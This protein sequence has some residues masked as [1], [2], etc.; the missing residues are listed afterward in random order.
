MIRV[1]IIED[2]TAAALN[3]RSLINELEPSAQIVTIL[4]SVADSVVWFGNEQNSA[5]VVFMDI[6]LAD[7]D[8]FNIFNH[9][10]IDVPIIFA[11]AYDQYALKAFEVN[12]IAYLLKPIKTSDL[13]RALDKFKLF[14]LAD[15]REYASRVVEA[16]KNRNQDHTFLIAIRDKL[17]PLKS[18]EI[19]FSYTF[20]ERVTITTNN[21]ST[22]PYDRSLDNMMALLPDADF[23]RANRQF[24]VSRRAVHDMSLW[25]GS[26]LCLNLVLPTPEKIIISKARVKALK[27]WIANRGK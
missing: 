2:E 19:A 9:S 13:R 15:R 18:S 21:G 4:E 6:H 14:T 25:F 27:E 20:N 16:M 7:G 24:I 5:D 3:L 10:S 11:T 23:F 26:R 1:V 12:S 22:F 17:I 8:A